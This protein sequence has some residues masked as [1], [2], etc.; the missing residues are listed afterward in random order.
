MVLRGRCAL[1]KQVDVL[2]LLLLWR[3]RRAVL[4]TSMHMRTSFQLGLAFSDVLYREAVFIATAGSMHAICATGTSHLGL[5]LGDIDIISSCW[6][7]TAEKIHLA[8]DRRFDVL[9][10]HRRGGRRGASGSPPSA[11]RQR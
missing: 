9:P 11:S 8:P 3:S 4:S 7:I 2:V 6:A 5:A 10:R 1:G